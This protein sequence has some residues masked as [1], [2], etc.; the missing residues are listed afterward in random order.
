MQLIIEFFPLISFFVAYVYGDIYLAIMVLMIATPIGLAIKYFRTRKLDK[1]YMWSTILLLV[2][3]SATLYFR[4]PY[5]IYW[6]PTVL[7]L[8]LALAFLISRWKA[9]EP[10]VRKLFGLSGELALEQ[11]TDS[12]WQRLNLIWVAFWIA[13]AVLNVIMFMNFSESIWVKFKVFGMM[14]IQVVF[15]GAQIFW[16]ANK[17]NDDEP[18]AN[19]GED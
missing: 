19:D 2:L 14:G 9:K 15:L 17:I 18:A 8:A 4:N 5:F 6:K 12:Q 3:G 10:L 7:Y 16:I 11:I 1:M 13:A